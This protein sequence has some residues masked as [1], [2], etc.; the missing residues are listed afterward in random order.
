MQT[1]TIIPDNVEDIIEAYLRREYER[2]KSAN[3]LSA[4]YLAVSVEIYSLRKCPGKFRSSVS[5]HVIDRDGVPGT[6]SESTLPE[7]VRLHLEAAKAFNP[8][9]RKRAE[10]DKAIKELADLELAE[11]ERG[12]A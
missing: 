4:D 6:Y 11:Q 5:T 9:S 8:V 10:I 12:V 2:L 1:T 3:V 7:A